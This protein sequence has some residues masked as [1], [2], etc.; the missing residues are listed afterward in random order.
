MSGTRP[1]SAAENPDGLE[2][3]RKRFA[4]F[5][6][7]QPIDVGIRPNQVGNRRTF[8]FHEIKRQ[9]HRLERDEQIREQ[10]GGVEI[11]PGERLERDGRSEVGRAADVEQ[12]VP[13][14]R[15]MLCHVA[16]A[17]R[18]NQTGVA[19]TGWRRQARRKRSVA[20]RLRGGQAHGL[21]RSRRDQGAGQRE[22]VFQPHRLEAE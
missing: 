1:S 17:W 12:R 4:R 5:D 22:Q 6:A 20:P 8:T 14:P 21:V 15:A 2:H 13:L 11:D 3:V 19:S 16:A 9:P 7:P 10:D 18:M